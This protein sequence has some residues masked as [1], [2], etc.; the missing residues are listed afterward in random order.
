V[1]GHGYTYSGHPVGCAVALKTLEIYQR[2]GIFDHAARVGGY[3][4]RQLKTFAEHPLVGEVRG[5]GLLAALELVAD[6]TSKTPFATGAV[7]A[8]CYQQCL[9]NGL[10]VRAVAGNSIALCP[11]LIIT[12][13]QVDELLA[14][15][16]SALDSTL[17][18]VVREATGLAVSETL[19]HAVQ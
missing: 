4:Q 13:A 8:H 19:K 15:L 1:F 2:D 7:G 12:E 10:I 17:E 18:F 16:R 3:F 5:V 14:K 6:K 11:P 9:E